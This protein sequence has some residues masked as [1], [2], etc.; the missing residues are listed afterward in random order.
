MCM[1]VCLIDCSREGKRHD[2]QQ[3]YLRVYVLRVR[4]WKRLRL[5]FEPVSKTNGV[6]VFV[7]A[8]LENYWL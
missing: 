7:C 4:T 2:G 8:G 5:T 1:C 3:S 6:L